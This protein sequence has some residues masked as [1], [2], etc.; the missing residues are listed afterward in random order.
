MKAIAIVILVSLEL[1]SA[2]LKIMPFG[3]SITYDDSYADIHNPRP[4]GFRSG[5]RNYLWYELSNSG[6]IVDFVGTRVAGASIE[7]YF[8]PDNEGYPGWTSY[9]LAERT[10]EWLAIDDPDV[11]L[12]H[13]GSNDWDKS[14][15]GIE[16][17]LNEV[18]R[19][20]Q[21]AGHQITVILALIIN[22]NPNEKWVTVFNRNVKAMADKRISKGDKIVIVDMENGAGLNYRE[23]MRDR[24]HP[25]DSGYQKM[26]NVWYQ[27]II[28]LPQ[29]NKDVDQFVRRTYIDILGREADESGLNYWRHTLQSTTAATIT[30]EFLESEEYRSRE[31]DSGSYITLLYHTLFDREPD[32]EGYSYWLDALESGDLNRGDILI[33][34]FDSGE[35]VELANRF[36]IE[37]ISEADKSYIRATDNI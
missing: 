37:P 4:E 2:P 24:T 11:I 34:F 6:Y 31:L 14:P 25:N 10:A 9:D 3:D 1:L 33:S 23:D 29:L 5:Y 35:F 15:S 7:P 18:D 13:A 20:E 26:A 19:Y 27:A 17:I 32:S 16:S 22:R 36:G 12:L 21:R 30:I 8:D 28:N